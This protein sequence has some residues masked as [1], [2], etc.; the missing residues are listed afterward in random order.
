MAFFMEDGRP[1]TLYVESEFDVDGGIWTT[2]ESSRI[3]KIV[4]C[5][6]HLDALGY[7]R[8][9]QILAEEVATAHRFHDDGGREYVPQRIRT[10]PPITI[11][12]HG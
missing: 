1:I 3:G 7:L 8:D 5:E 4:S 12:I 6:Q 11:D 2:A 9:L 10:E